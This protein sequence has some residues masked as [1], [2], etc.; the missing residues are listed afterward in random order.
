MAE[1]ARMSV[2]AMYVDAVWMTYWKGH[3][4]V[5]FGE[6]GVSEVTWRVAIVLEEKDVETLIQRLQ[7]VLPNMKSGVADDS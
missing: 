5:T 2:P 6:S 1:T 7:T 3:V 4:R